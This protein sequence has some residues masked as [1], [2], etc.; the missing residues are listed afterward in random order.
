MTLPKD[1]KPL[2]GVAR[3]LD[4]LFA[5]AAPA[6]TP[7]ARAPAPV[8]PPAVRAAPVEEPSLLPSASD[9]PLIGDVVEAPVAPYPAPAPPQLPATEHE[10][11]EGPLLDADVLVEEIAGPTA[12]RDQPDPEEERRARLRVAMDSLEHAVDAI[13]AGEGDADS[14]ARHAMEDATLLRAAGG[15]QRTSNVC[16]GSAVEQ[17]MAARAREAAAHW[18]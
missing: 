6:E 3:S 16:S 12:T 8:P 9:F 1:P 18:H 13:V 17:P 5:Q 2:K 15:Q 4:D 10:I 14:L 11:A 7:V